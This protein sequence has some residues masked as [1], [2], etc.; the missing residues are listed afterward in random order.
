MRQAG[1]RFRTNKLKDALITVLQV[2]LPTLKGHGN[3]PVFLFF[4]ENQF[5]MGPLHN[6]SSPDFDFKFGE[7]FV[8]H[9]SGSHS[10]YQ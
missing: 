3:A 2:L 8:I 4:C 7:I 10:E 9:E 1:M 6:L 5:G